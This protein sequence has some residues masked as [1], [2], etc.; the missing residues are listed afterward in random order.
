LKA[1]YDRE[2]LLSAFQLVSSVVPARSPKAILTNVKLITEPNRSVLM[3]TDLEVVGVRLEVR[4]VKT[5]EPGE[6]L[7]PTA[8]FLSI[9]RESTDQ[10]LHLEADSSSCKVTGERSEFELPGEDPAQ[11]PDIP[12]FDG[13]NYHQLQAGALRDMIARTI[14]AAA[15]EN[16]RYALT[17]VLWELG[18]EKVRLV[19]TD[20]RRLAVTETIGM[21]QGK[22]TTEGQTPVVPTKAMSLLERN[23]GDPEQPVMVSIRANEALFKTERAMIYGRLVEGRYPPYREVFPKKTSTKVKFTVGPFLSAV[24]QAAILTDEDSRGVEFNFAKNKLT[25]KARVAD[26]GRAK[27]ETPI[28][29]DGKGVDINFDPRFL[30]DMLRVLEPDAE[31]TVDLA[32]SNSAALFKAGDS[33]SYIV[34]PL[35]RENR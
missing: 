22:H 4:G 35:S 7:L 29:C 14:F 21:Q 24:K 2:G 34:M 26:K 12:S 6:A 11:Y 32:D 30:V 8:R 3:A 28:E 19:A 9:L 23:L 10:E 1:I 18:P 5:E 15:Q 31:V 27:V 20:G 16:A 25:L 17:G 33:Y 13:D